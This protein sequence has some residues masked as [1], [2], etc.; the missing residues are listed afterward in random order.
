MGQI[1][2]ENLTYS[3]KTYDTKTGTESLSKPVLKDINLEFDTDSI[4]LI[5]GAT[6]SGKSTLLK[7]IKKL[8]PDAALLYQNPE[9]QI[10]T[11]KVWHEVAFGL[12]NLGLS[13]VQMD[14]RLAEALSFFRLEPIAF[15]DTAACSGGQKQIICL[16]SLLAMKPEILLLDEPLS[17]LDPESAEIFINTLNRLHKI[18]GITII[19][20]E[21]DIH[22][23]LPLAD[24]VITIKDG[25]ILSDENSHEICEKD[26]IAKLCGKLASDAVNSQYQNED[27]NSSIASTDRINKTSDTNALIIK[28]LYFRYDKKTDD[29]LRGLSANFD[30]GKIVSIFGSNAAGKSTLLHLLAGILKPN[31]GKIILKQK[32]A[33]IGYLPQYV[34]TLFIAETIREE[35]TIYN[36]SGIQN[37]FVES[38]LNEITDNDESSL[39]EFMDKNPY[40]LSGGQKQLLGLLKI[41]THNPSILLL[42]EPTKGMD[43]RCKQLLASLLNGLK[44]GGTTIIL[45]THDIP[46][47]YSCADMFTILSMGKLTI[48]QTA[49]EFFADNTLYDIRVENIK[50]K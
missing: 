26:I 8:Y 14:N 47:A 12:E 35:L 16:A 34:E 49:N 13:Q 22:S 27:N 4:T 10:V 1:K 2:I 39:N 43:Y 32:K 46:F 20:A 41:L 44:L 31:E 30:E 33:V 42:D 23:I 24:R 21:H 40:D 28:D 37:L 36:T 15:K 38:F 11:D 18:L 50:S 45:S 17:Q 19:I 9:D 5:C 29:I 6:G 48:P 3:Y 7:Q 25:S